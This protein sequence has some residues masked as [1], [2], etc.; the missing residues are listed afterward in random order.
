MAAFGRFA[1]QLRVFELQG[2][3]VD[4]HRLVVALQVLVL[5]LQ[6]I[7]GDEERAEVVLE[8]RVLRAEVHQR[9][10][11]S[12]RL[13][14]FVLEF[15]A[16]PLPLLLHLGESNKCIRKV[17]RLVVD[18]DTSLMMKPNR[19]NLNGRGHF[20]VEET[21][22]AFELPLRRLQLLL[23]ADEGVVIA[24]ELLVQLLQLALIPRQLIQQRLR[25][26]QLLGKAVA[27][28]LHRRQRRLQR[29]VGH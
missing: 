14:Q 18:V 23:L 21:Q 25:R 13:V 24:G 22:F 2:V 17:V 10:V 6:L 28:G 3:V 20:V 29:P 4:A 8:A 16:G 19:S 12:F 1:L 11:L 9:P 26:P 7:V 5:V 15:A 27:L